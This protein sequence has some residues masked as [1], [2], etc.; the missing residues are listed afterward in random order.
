MANDL[1][2]EDEFTVTVPEALVRFLKDDDDGYWTVQ[3]NGFAL[4]DCFADSE[5]QGVL[6]EFDPQLRLQRLKDEVSRK[7]MEIDEL[8][9]KLNAT[10]D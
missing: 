5:A 6:E 2:N 1:F 7:S 10:Q 9:E 8:E 3:V 4:E